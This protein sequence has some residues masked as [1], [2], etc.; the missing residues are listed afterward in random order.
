MGAHQ[1]RVSERVWFSLT[2]ALCAGA[3]AAGGN[4]DER[5]QL[6]VRYNS[7]VRAIH[8]VQADVEVESKRLSPP[9]EW[10]IKG[11]YSR[12]W[13]RVRIHEEWPNSHTVDFQVK[14]GVVTWVSQSLDAQRPGE[15]AVR[16]RR[17]AI[18][19]ACDVWGLVA[20]LPT[21]DS[22]R[23]EM[24]HFLNIP[25]ENFAIRSQSDKGRKQVV[26]KLVH[27]HREYGGPVEKEVLFEEESG[28]LPRKTTLR[29]A[30]PGEQIVEEAENQDFAEYAP[31]VLF[32]G[33]RIVRKFI[34]AKMSQETVLTIRNLRINQPV[35]DESLRM[36]YP[37]R[38]LLWD[39]IQGKKVRVNEEGEEI[40]F[41]RNEGQTPGKGPRD[42]PAALKGERSPSDA[43]SWSAAFWIFIASIGLLM[44]AS[45]LA[46]IRAW[47]RRRTASQ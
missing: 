2:L 22:T 15:S 27:E 23:S 19:S 14:D 45:G 8:S 6:L 26:L 46:G 10:R 36:Q 30:I 40:E 24:S 39:K 21:P 37:F 1:R 42:V 18:P 29:Y 16:Q 47:K 44:V 3:G 33:R 38:V 5:A 12:S 9:A 35:S 28:F 17:D 31:G 25:T 11:T 32:P 20:L 13:D 7:T 34:N 43:G 4:A 41:V